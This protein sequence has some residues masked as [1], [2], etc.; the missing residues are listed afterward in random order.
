MSRCMSILRGIHCGQAC[1]HG[2]LACS[3]VSADCFMPDGSAEQVATPCVPLRL[4]IKLTLA[5]S[6][7][8]PVIVKA[9]LQLAC[10]R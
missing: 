2:R 4:C 3:L 5:P 7:L 10:I 9:S 8:F 1:G 6:I